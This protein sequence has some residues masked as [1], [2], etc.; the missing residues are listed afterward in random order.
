MKLKM[1][2]KKSDED[3]WAR[4]WLAAALTSLSFPPAFDDVI[5]L[6][7]VI[8]NGNEMRSE[9]RLDAHLLIYYCVNA[10]KTTSDIICFDNSFHL[11]NVCEHVEFL[12]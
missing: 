1:M 9:W 10:R 3:E 5:E 2:R 7:I 4:N 8:G 12:I 6:L 11:T